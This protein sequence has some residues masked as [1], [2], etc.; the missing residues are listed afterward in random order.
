MKIYDFI[1]PELEFYGMKI[2]GDL[3]V[4]VCELLHVPYVDMREY[5]SISD[6][7]GDHVHLGTGDGKYGPQKQV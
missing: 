6:L 7:G 2:R 3:M 1:E 4:Q 5:I